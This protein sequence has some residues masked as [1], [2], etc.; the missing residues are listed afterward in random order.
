MTR[1]LLILIIAFAAMTQTNA[2]SF[3]D[4]LQRK[5][6]GK[7]NV[8]VRQSTEID[9][10]VNGKKN[11][12]KTKKQLK[13]EKKAAKAA[14]KEAKRREK[15][16]RKAAKAAAKAASKNQRPTPVVPQKPV[17]TVTP[18]LPKE[19]VE[20]KKAPDISKI[21]RTTTKLV[22]RVKIGPDGRPVT[23]KEVRSVRY[24]GIKKVA[25]Y[26]IQVYFGGNKREDKNAAEQIG[27]KVKAAFPLQPVYVHFYSPRWACRVGNFEDRKEAQELLK[28]MRKAGFRQA[29]I[30]ECRVTVRDYQIID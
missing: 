5:Q 12:P 22:R 13:A 9:N 23:H 16:E 10:L 27:H 30:I 2:Q 11:T 6:Q 19:V 25:G 15:E 29:V 1:Y 20:V 18:E 4:N 3:T 21:K 14:A 24:K 8:S 17:V 28:E 7:G 26:R